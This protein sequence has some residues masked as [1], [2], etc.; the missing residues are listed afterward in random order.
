MAVAAHAFIFDGQITIDRALNSPTLTVR[1]ANA[2]AALVELRVN[3]ESIATRSVSSAKSSGETTFTLNLSSLAAGDN[4]VEIRLFDKAGKLLATE[5]TTVT[6]ENSQSPVFLTNPKMGATLQG[7]VDIKVGFG[8]QMKNSYVSFFIDNQFKSISNVPPYEF[9]WDTR[10]DSNGWHEVEAWVVDE[11]SA[12]YKTRK[13]RVF[14]Q[15]PGGR[16][17]RPG[18]SEPVAKPV[19]APVAKPILAET[20]ANALHL[21]VGGS[22]STKPATLKPSI[23]SGPKEMLPTGKRLM[24]KVQKPLPPTNAIHNAVAAAGAG[25]VSITRGARL[26]SVGAFAIVYNT[27]FVD[28][29]V[30]PRVTEDGIPLTPL[31]YLLEKAGGKVDW[32]NNLKNVSAKADG[33]DIFLHIGDSFA[34]INKQR[35]ELERP[36]FI[37][38][39]RTIVPLSFM[40]DALNVNIDY[41]KAT[42]HVLITSIKK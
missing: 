5:T 28:F 12:T 29:D 39:G 10:G 35:I 4:K 26:P 31:R 27:Q 20:T 42:G 23:S 19:V 6:A 14:V 21:T 40:R 33:H 24:T 41:D 32:Q 1:Y 34:Q 25:V 38:R 18:V 30:Q 9:T 22:T 11:S 16:T 2:N 37:D 7:N 15:N 36:S 13:V 17:D 8:Q 3:G